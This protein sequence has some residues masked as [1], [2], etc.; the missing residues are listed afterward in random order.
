MISAP[1]ET[2]LV[3]LKNSM[4][5]LCGRPPLHT[6]HVGR[7]PKTPVSE[8]STVRTSKVLKQISARSQTDT[9]V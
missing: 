6:V 7:L 4:F 2:S 3:N 9:R 5:S 8:G 1:P